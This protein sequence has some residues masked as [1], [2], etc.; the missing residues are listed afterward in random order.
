MVGDTFAK[1]ICTRADYKEN[2]KKVV[3]EILELDTI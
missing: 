1:H 2:T 3:G